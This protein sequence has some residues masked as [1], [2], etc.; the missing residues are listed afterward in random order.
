MLKLVESRRAGCKNLE[1]EG[2]RFRKNKSVQSKIYWKCV[3]NN[4]FSTVT[5]N[6]QLTSLVNLPSKHN[7]PPKEN[8]AKRDALK[9]RIIQSVKKDPTK[10]ISEIYENIIEDVPENDENTIP[11]FDHIRQTLYYHRKS[12]LP[13]IP[14]RVSDINFTGS[15]GK[16]TTGKQFL[17]AKSDL[18]GIVIF[19]TR[20]FIKNLTECE[21]ILS[22]GTFRTA[23]V[24]FKQIYTI[25]G[26]LNRRKI[27]LVF[28]FL[29]KKDTTSYRYVLQVIAE[30]AIS[31]G[32]VF[33]P[34]N[35]LCDYEKGFIKAV[36]E[37]F[38]DSNLCGCHFH[39][40]QALFRKIQK[41][42]L[43][44]GYKSNPS[45]SKFFRR[46]FSLPYIPIG[47]VRTNYQRI[48]YDRR[49]LLLIGIY[50]GLSIFLDYFE[51]TWLDGHFPIKMWNLFN[52]AVSLATTNA[53]EGWNNRWNRKIGRNHPNFWV[54]VRKL[55]TEE[56]IAKLSLKSY[57]REEEPPRQ[58]AK[59]KR[60][61][62]Q[63][64]ALKN[65][66]A[67]GNRTLENYWGTLCELMDIY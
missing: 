10:N 29:K 21:T 32:K 7:H 13:S 30:K 1:I 33:R 48:K 5:T 8:E 24:Q 28:A 40:S 22:D 51:K 62:S 6:L 11:R 49:T 54:A 61:Q 16:T 20:F 47:L 63:I 64:R 65:S 4:C 19:S 37:D 35:F 12:Q 52:R 67:C 50:P 23:P 3:E 31:L 25:F 38:P 14:Y 36:S 15:W 41:F 39:Y 18:F 27:P 44:G 45:L 34:E 26:E 56:K 57:L 60:K 42:H 46:L 43:A 53:F 9:Q 58:R 55:K 66:Y 17:L 2:Y 59:Y